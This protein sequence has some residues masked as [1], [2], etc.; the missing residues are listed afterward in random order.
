MSFGQR[1]L[2]RT[3]GRPQ[4]LLGRLGGHIMARMNR[5]C[6]QSVLA[7]LD[8]QPSERILE[9]GFGSGVGIALASRAA[10]SVAG[11]DVSREMVAQAAARNAAEVANG[12]VD[13]RLAQADQLPFANDAFD[14]AFAINSMQV[15]PDAGA[16]LREIRRVLKPGG[17]IA[18]GFTPN[19][20]GGKDGLCDTIKSAGFS[21][22]RLFDVTG[23]YCVLAA[24]PS[25]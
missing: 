8:V 7:A 15:W 14:S 11:A 16:A 25:R 18:L 21:Q 17:R 6:A 20:G 2:L 24:K 19:S 13:L 12:R 10:Q 4:G 22:V 23:G 1:L 9:I 3:F 5:Q